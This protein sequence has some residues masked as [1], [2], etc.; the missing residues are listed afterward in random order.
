MSELV[1]YDTEGR[2]AV[3]TI[4]RPEKLNA[5]SPAVGDGL[6]AAWRR[7]NDSDARVAILT[8]SGER[9]F[10]AGADLSEAGD[11][12]PFIPGIGIDVD[13]PVIAAV[14]GHCIGGA[15][16]LVTFCDLCIAADNTRFS[17]PESKVGVSGGLITSLAARI[18]HKVAMEFMYGLED[19]IPIC[20]D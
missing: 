1:T 17:Y 20:I 7:F 8:G 15:V 18:P 11:L 14:H 4:N 16:V 6:L 2:V 5:L 13:K 3:I 12:W 19:L 10:S 9:A